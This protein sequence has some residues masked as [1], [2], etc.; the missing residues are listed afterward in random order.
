M[1]VGG[2]ITFPNVLCII[3]MIQINKGGS[4]SVSVCQE[5]YLQ[6]FIVKAEVRV[7]LHVGKLH[8]TQ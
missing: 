6:T 4:R 7:A 1:V 2:Y 3:K 5:F 8:F